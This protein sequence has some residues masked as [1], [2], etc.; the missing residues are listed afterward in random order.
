MDAL[1]EILKAAPQ[2]LILGALGI[3]AIVVIILPISLRVA[4]LT[5]QQIADLLTLTMQFFVNLLQEFRSQNKK[6]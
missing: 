4:G 3:V 6:E 5:G 1:A 2:S